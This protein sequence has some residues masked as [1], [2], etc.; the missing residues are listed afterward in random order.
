MR[1]P[2]EELAYAASTSMRPVIRKS[3][4]VVPELLGSAAEAYLARGLTK[5]T[6]TEWTDPPEPESMATSIEI[7]GEIGRLLDDLDRL[8]DSQKDEA[9]RTFLPRQ[10]AGESLLR[11]S[12]LP[13]LNQSLGGEGVAAR[14]GAMPL[15]VVLESD[16]T[17]IQIASLLSEVS[18]GT[19]GMRTEVGNE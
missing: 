4:F 2:V 6:R 11:T 13:L 5:T 9:L 7:P 17:L 10:T 16:G 3:V 14:L 1:L 8:V 12:L 15:K 18:A 19:I